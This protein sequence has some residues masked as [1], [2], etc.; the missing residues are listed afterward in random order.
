MYTRL[1]LAV[2]SL[3]LAGCLTSGG[4]ALE[5]APAAKYRKIVVAAVR[6]PPEARREAEAR[7][8]AEITRRGAVAIPLSSLEFGDEERSPKVLVQKVL[9]TGAQAVFV[10][11]PFVFRKDG[12]TVVKTVILSGLRD[13]HTADV[14]AEPPLTYKTALFDVDR[15]YRVWMTDVNSVEQE[16]KAYPALATEAAGEAVAKAVEAGVL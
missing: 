10:L 16:G 13:L 2:L 12:N 6:M 8:A 9:Q 4:P 14:V 11:D 7:L 15:I 5:T 3:A 1:V